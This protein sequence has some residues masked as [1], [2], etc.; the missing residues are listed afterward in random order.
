MAYSIGHQYRQKICMLTRHRVINL[1]RSLVLNLLRLFCFSAD[2]PFTLC[3]EI[4]LTKKGKNFI[5]DFFSFFF[6]RFSS[7]FQFPMKSVLFFAINKINGKRGQMMK[8]PQPAVRN[9]VRFPFPLKPRKWKKRH[10]S[11][12]SVILS[13][14]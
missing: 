1:S 10:V 5:V 2:L 13:F 6:C 7:V 8:K 14:T 3:H 9:R 4:D 12:Y 11:L